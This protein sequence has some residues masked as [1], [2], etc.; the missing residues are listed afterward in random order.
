MEEK[1]YLYKGGLS[2]VGKSGVGSAVCHQEQMLAAIGA[3]VTK[4]WDEASVVHIN[5]VFPDS[6]LA[7]YFAGKQKK[8]VVYYGHST[9]EDFRNSFIGS[10]LAAPLFQKWICRCYE[11]GDVILTPTEYS[12]RLL[13]GYGLRKPIYSI[14][15]GVDTDFFKK[16]VDAG[17]RFRSRYQISP[18]KKVVI[19][20][21]HLI[22]RKGILEFLELASQMPEVLFFWFGGGNHWAIPWDVKQ[23]LRRKTENVIFAGYVSPGELRDAYCGADAFAFLSYEETEG[24]VVL[25]ALSCE[26]P[27][28]IR[29]IPVYDGWLK[30]GV[31]VYKE[32]D[33][34]SFRE[35][36]EM[37]F[38]SD[39][40]KLT[41][42]GHRLAKEHG[43]C[44]TGMA[45]K[46]IY[47]RE[48]LLAGLGV[49]R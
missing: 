18:D 47:R 12:R 1:I 11:M 30:N 10:N 45:L 33:T 36:L 22:R 40:S 26:I 35:R 48:N 39:C 4:D 15:N 38:T 43:L 34:G 21:G 46:E 20:A 23:A 5:T 25:E 8:K 6:V 44:E 37:I 31:H 7:A 3:P 27:V 32:T 42:E 49:P 9:M 2:I 17:R 28:V 29:D 41:E 16:S 24:I 13:V 14:T 19:S